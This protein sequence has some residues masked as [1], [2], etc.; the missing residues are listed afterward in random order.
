[1]TVNE[2]VGVQATERDARTVVARSAVP[3]VPACFALAYADV[4]A[5][6]IGA[7]EGAALG[8][9]AAERLAIGSFGDATQAVR[10]VIPV[11]ADP[12]VTTVTIDHVL[13]RSGR[14]I[15]TLTFEN[16]AE[17]TPVETIGAVAGAAVARLAS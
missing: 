7:G 6:L 8:A 12:T 14:S 13:I 10:V 1:L 11:T 2:H 5:S 16:S 15:V 4:S 17:A 9:A 3:D